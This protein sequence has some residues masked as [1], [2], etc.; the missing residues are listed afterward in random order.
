MRRSCEQ[1]AGP[2]TRSSELG[3]LSWPLSYS[4]CDLKPHFPLQALDY[5][6]CLQLHP[7]VSI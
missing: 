1:S 7:W 3:V 5:L 6:T 4:L 2:E